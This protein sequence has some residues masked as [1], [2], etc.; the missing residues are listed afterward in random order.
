MT[1]TSGTPNSMFWRVAATSGFGELAQGVADVVLPLIAVGTLGAT[2]WQASA[3]TSA[4]SVGLVAFGLLA[5]V[6]ADR[7][8]RVSVITTANLLRAAAFLALPIGGLFHVVN[9]PML[10]LLGV[11]AGACGVFADAAAQALTPTIASEE[12]LLA[13]NSQLL[14]V[15]SA[16]QIGAPALAGTM[17]QWLSSQVAAG[18]TSIGYF[19]AAAPL[20]GCHAIDAARVTGAVA[21]GR[22]PNLMREL[23]DGFTELWHQRELRS[24]IACTATFNFAYGMLQPVFFPFLLQELG[25]SEGIVGLVLAMGGIGA[26]LAAIFAEKVVARIGIGAAIWLPAILAGCSI[27]AM[28]L[29]SPRTALL[30][31][32]LLQGVLSISVTV[33]NIT[34]F[35]LRQAGTSPD[36]LGRV[37]VSSRVI[38]L[39]TAPL[40]SFFAASSMIFFEIRGS[41]IASGSIACLSSLWILVS[42]I[43][44]VQRMTEFRRDC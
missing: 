27:A 41:L 25:V 20:F 18:V 43:R 8:N 40:G 39:G 14:A 19:L 6:V 4:E 29:L 28:A 13:R 7:Y 15:D 38:V 30:V 35:T 5:G 34:V 42:P 32:G 17:T 37:G 24:T 1:T 16:T 44:K 21:P 36:I 23:K 9:T 2:G 3:V 22:Q 12:A 31:G 10:I 33:Y 11:I 26:V